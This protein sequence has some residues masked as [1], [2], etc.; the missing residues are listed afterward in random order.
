MIESKEWQEKD[1]F[2]D[3]I[4]C[5]IKKGSR[6]LC[7]Y[8]GV[9]KSRSFPGFNYKEMRLYVNHDLS[10]SRCILGEGWP[11]D[12]YWYA[13][14]YPPNM[15]AWTFEALEKEVKKVACDF[16]KIVLFVENLILE[17]EKFFMEKISDELL[18]YLY[19]QYNYHN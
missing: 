8:F 2:E 11:K 17:H 1:W 13:W 18:E 16:K 10:F 19:K 5:L 9:P 3:G 6:S 12:Y 14:D 4:R 7:A 15:N